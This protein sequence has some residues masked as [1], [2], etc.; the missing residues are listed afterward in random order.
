MSQHA[1]AAKTKAHVVDAMFQLNT[2]GPLAL[3]QAVLP[4]M[5][6][7]GKGHIVVISSMAGIMPAPGQAIYA[8]TKHAFM[9]YF[10]TVRTELSATSIGV[11]ICCPGP[12]RFE[13]DVLM[14][15][16]YHEEGIVKK[17]VAQTKGL[18]VHKAVKLIALA[19][20]HRMRECWMAKQ[21]ILLMAYIMQYIPTIGSYIMDMIGPR[22]S[23]AVKKGDGYSIKAMLDKK[24]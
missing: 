15:F 16:A 13:E 14:R 10:H 1:L 17:E 7:R 22:R 21:P 2:I 12:I 20:E 24:G 3:T 23:A 6:D 8:A 19:I 9:G 4:G 5:V 18:P 11:T